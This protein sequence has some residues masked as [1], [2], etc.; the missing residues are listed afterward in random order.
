MIGGNRLTGQDY[1]P[2]YAHIN[3]ANVHFFSQFQLVKRSLAPPMKKL[4]SSS[5]ELECKSFNSE[6]CSTFWNSFVI[7]SFAKLTRYN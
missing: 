5:S 6:V 4:H 2:P 1:S 3:P 7:S